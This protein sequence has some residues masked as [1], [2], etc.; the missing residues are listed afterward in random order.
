MKMIIFVMCMC[1]S[2]TMMVVACAYA[3]TFLQRG[4]LLA[5]VLSFATDILYLCEYF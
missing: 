1:G 2:T 5:F 4:G 3:G